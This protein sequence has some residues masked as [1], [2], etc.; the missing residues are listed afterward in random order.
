MEKKDEKNFIIMVILQL[1]I[2]I[3]IGHW[4]WSNNIIIIIRLIFDSVD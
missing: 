3:I 1:D 4:P 2:I